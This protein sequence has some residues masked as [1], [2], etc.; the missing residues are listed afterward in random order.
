MRPPKY[1]YFLLVVGM[2]LVYL[3]SHFF[4]SIQGRMKYAI[5]LMLSIAFFLLFYSLFS[6]RKCWRTIYN[7]YVHRENTKKRILI[8]TI[9][10]L[11][12]IGHFGY[13]LGGYVKVPELPLNA[14]NISIS[15]LFSIISLYLFFKPP[16]S[17]TVLMWFSLIWGVILRILIMNFC[18]LNYK[19][20]DMLFVIDKAC[21]AF[22]KGINPYILRRSFDIYKDWAPLIGYL[23]F[24][25][26]WYLPSKFLGLDIRFS[27]LISNI[28]LFI[29]LIRLLKIQRKE[30]IFL[31]AFINSLIFVFPPYLY[32]FAY[33][34]VNLYWLLLILF[35]WSLKE[36]KFY[37]SSLIA[38][39]LIS[40]RRGAIFIIVISILYLIKN[41]SLSKVIKWISLAGVI[42]ILSVLS[43]VLWDF[44]NF[45]YSIT[46]LDVIYPY[47]DKISLGGWISRIVNLETS[48]IISLLFPFFV[49]LWYLGNKD[50]SFSLY[51]KTAIIS[52]LGFLIFFPIN[53]I[54]YY[55]PLMLMSIFYIFVCI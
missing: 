25:W 6:D 23:P 4:Y 30:K 41:Y 7:A 46:F 28:L 17:Y 10:I 35:L 22:L 13:F 29:V 49:Y 44:E 34:E 1:F 51:L 47:L 8:F 14:E 43:F 3:V 39:L 12:N 31:Y 36:R 45:R 11:S 42:F 16:K 53:H 21:S 32:V 40:I 24:T 19:I 54:Y 48:I 18:P 27:N 20:A 55:G 52:Y 26:F 15:V 37:F 2:F 5:F 50:K 38:G 9:F 33:D